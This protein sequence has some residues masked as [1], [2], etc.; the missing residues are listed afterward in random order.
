MATDTLPAVT[1]E[2]S[3][4]GEQ[5]L[6]ALPID[7]GRA[8]IFWDLGVPG[9]ARL[10]IAFDGASR[11]EHRVSA[12][13]GDFFVRRD[14]PFRR[15][16]AEISA[17]DGT[18]RFAA[19]VTLPPARHGDEPVR[20]GRQRPAG[21]G[22]GVDPAIGP[23]RTPQAPLTHR[24]SPAGSSEHGSSRFLGASETFVAAAAHGSQSR[25]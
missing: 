1:R 22:A 18:V 15:L 2:P 4:T 10:R 5:F 24:R 17:E 13:M 11:E 19:S 6:R 7:P 25:S 3:R 21:A 20:W 23:D 12:D 9:A 14:A 16:D 8:W